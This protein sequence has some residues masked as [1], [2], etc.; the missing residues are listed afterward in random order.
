VAEPNPPPN[1]KQVTAELRAALSRL[2]ESN[3]YF[4]FEALCRDYARARLAP[5]IRPATGPV[6]AG[7]DGGRDFDTYHSFLT[8]SSSD[9]G[10]A[11]RLPEGVVA[12][13]CTLQQG[14]LEAKVRADVA[15]ILAGSDD[16]AG[17]YVFMSA[18]LPVGRR[19]EL[20]AEARDAHGTQL[21]ILDGP[22]LAEGLADPDL[23]WMAE[24]HLSLRGLRSDAS[25]R[26]EVVG[27]AG[28]IDWVT[29]YGVARSILRGT[30]GRLP[31][32]ART[33]DLELGEAIA[34][35]IDGE[36][37]TLILVEGEARAGKTHA[38]AAALDAAAAG[39]LVLTAR[40]P[41]ELR[42]A[43]A[44]DGDEPVAVL[45]DPVEPVVDRSSGG[46]GPSEF[47]RSATEAPVVLIGIRSG[48]EVPGIRELEVRADAI[49]AVDTALTERELDIARTVVCDSDLMAEAALWGLGP[50]L[51]AAPLLTRTYRLAGGAT[52]DSRAGWQVVET[53]LAWRAAGMR[54]QPGA[55]TLRSLW[56]VLD[57]SPS[58]DRWRR[59]LGWCTTEVAPGQAPLRRLH[60]TWA[61]H[62]AL[63]E[64]PPR[65]GWQAR[66]LEQD[67]WQILVA[68]AGEA[69]GRLASLGSAAWLMG[70]A[71]LGRSMM[72][73][74]SDRGSLRARFNL[75]VT[76]L[77]E[78]PRTTP[79]GLEKARALLSSL[80][81]DLL[82]RSCLDPPANNLLADATYALARIDHADDPTAAAAGYRD[83]IALGSVDAMVN[84]AQLERQL[85]RGAGADRR[86]RDAVERGST[87]AA[88]ALVYDGGALLD[89]LLDDI[90]ASQAEALGRLLLSSDRRPEALQAL[91]RASAAGRL[92]ATAQLG[93]M[94]LTADATR[95]LEL[96]ESAAARG[97][98]AAMLY[99]GRALRDSK[100]ARARRLLTV[101]HD[102]GSDAAGHELAAWDAAEPSPS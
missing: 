61:L 72:V 21:Q 68:W 66:W 56:D 94:L 32:A 27:R 102:L 3:G 65:R 55:D 16:I 33:A 87:K 78:T 20:E 35:G 22:A 39:T 42:A 77:R 11:A 100:P 49:V 74:A 30:D 71:A 86:L 67:V 4:D 82:Q 45:L 89:E 41:V 76:Y 19:Q 18:A 31:H 73:A 70:E 63:R 98:R 75:A 97:S 79:G 37:A 95:A 36:G 93:G 96:L 8:P 83:A 10:F 54:E 62:P 24:Q 92:S 9:P 53:L 28:A 23:L 47:D 69:P 59:A 7:G 34:R 99:L 50:V 51:I 26:G 46:V 88:A 25:S 1:R 14:G 44:R 91:E 90:D 60:G 64:L 5:N 15:R 38:V 2:G 58:P 101:A 57:R 84:L 81:N 43:L 80:C 12:F 52:G 13:A 85:G 40:T 29:G 17:I 6:G 48:E